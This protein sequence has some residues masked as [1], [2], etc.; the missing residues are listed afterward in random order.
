MRTH[1]DVPDAQAPT[2]FDRQNTLRPLFF[3]LL[4]LLNGLSGQRVLCLRFV[5]ATHQTADPLLAAKPRTVIDY[6]FVINLK[7]GSMIGATCYGRFQRGIE[8]SHPKVKLDL[9]SHWYPFGPITV[10]SV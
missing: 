8:P 6:C 4:T 2:A 1:R 10:C 7:T 9:L 3:A 5:P